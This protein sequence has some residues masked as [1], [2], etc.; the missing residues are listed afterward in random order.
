MLFRSLLGWGFP[1][2]RGGPVSH[3]HR[4]GVGAFV[5]LCDQLADKHGRRFTPPALLR[6]MAARQAAFYER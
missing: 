2:F 1:A 3:I 5:A 6:D 4:V